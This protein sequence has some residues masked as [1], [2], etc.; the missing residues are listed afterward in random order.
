MSVY[1]YN[2][3]HAGDAITVETAG[4]YAALLATSFMIGRTVAAVP[5][6]GLADVYGRKWVLIASLLGSGLSSLWFGMCSRYGGIG[7]AVVARGVMG[8]L[9]STVGVSKT[10]ASELAHYDFDDDD[11]SDENGEVSRLS[12]VSPEEQ[13]KGNREQLETRIV[14][15]TMSM[16][17]W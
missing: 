15:L 12:S 10:M 17:A 5:W 4:P 16:R 6:G 13:G 8:A 2:S 11:N 9:N 7:G 1:L 14:G 3:D